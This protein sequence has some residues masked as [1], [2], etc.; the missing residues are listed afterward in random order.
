MKTTSIGPFTLYDYAP[1]RESSFRNEV[2]HGLSLKKKAIPCK[3]F[4]DERGSR[5]FDEICELDEY[6]P[7]RTE[8][9]I[10]RTHNRAIARELGSRPLLIELGSGSGNKTRLV[11]DYLDDPAA[12]VPIDIARE[13][14]ISS[15]ALLLDAYADRGL[16]V[17]PVCA[18]YTQDFDIPRARRPTQNLVFY[19]PGSTIGNLSPEEATRFLAHLRSL[20]RGPCGLLVGADLK[21]DRSVLELAYNDGAGVTAA[22]NLNVLARINRELDADFVLDRFRHRAFY[23]EREGR[24]EMHLVSTCSQIVR[25]GDVTI[26]FI[27]G[28]SILTEHSY[29]FSADDMTHIAT[30]SGFRV[31]RVWT[32][33]K[34][35]FSVQLL[36][37]T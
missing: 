5:L 32:D 36:R 29:K 27:E 25:V 18:D 3:F 16:E 1:T 23:N 17:L 12:Y 34:S 10:L 2:L 11:L 7:T 28:E 9:A 35:L 31:D 8:L 14:L 24:I 26:P 15:A 33:E 30:R 37:S 6:Y 20:A 21:K 4:Y 19:F 13:H 22:F